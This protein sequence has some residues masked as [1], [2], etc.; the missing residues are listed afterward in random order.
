MIL[1]LVA[2]G[3]AAERAPMSNERVPPLEDY[4]LSSPAISEGQVFIRTA[5]FLWAIGPRRQDR[6]TP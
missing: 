4:I 1:A 3:G 6:G 2:C 5:G